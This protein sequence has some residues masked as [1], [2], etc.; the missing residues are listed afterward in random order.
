[1]AFLTW[2][3]VGFVCF[4]IHAYA[5]PGLEWKAFHTACYSTVILFIYLSH[6][7]AMWSDPGLVPLDPSAAERFELLKGTPEEP[8]PRFWCHKCNAFKPEGSHHCSRCKR[9]VHRMDHHCPWVNNCVGAGNLKY[10]LLFL[11][12]VGIGCVYS[13]GLLAYRLSR[14]AY[15]DV[16][17]PVVVDGNAIIIG[18][19]AC[20]LSIF[21]FGFV[22]C[23]WC[24]QHEALVTST[25]K[26]DAM[27]GKASEHAPRPFLASLS[28]EAFGEPLSWRWLLPVP[29]R[30]GFVL[31]IT[32]EHETTEAEEEDEEEEQD[33]AKKER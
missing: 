28:A 10:F 11:S 16:K 5:I 13:V 31:S 30:G 7:R 22:S 19:V 21:F 6:A 33:E 4:A 27:Q 25:P 1:M 18:V 15:R 20:V 32:Y 24:D 2:V 23:M 9:C 8:L 26:I 29:P 17:K 12:Y 14:F 3:V